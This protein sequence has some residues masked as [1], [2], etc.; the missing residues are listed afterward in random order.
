[1]SAIS[2]FFG[3]YGARRLDGYDPLSFLFSPPSGGD[4]HEATDLD[5]EIPAESWTALDCEVPANWR[6]DEWEARPRRFIDG[7]DVGDTAAWLLAPSGEPVPVRLSQIGA[8]IIE[9]EDGEMSRIWEEVEPVVSFVADAFP[10]DDVERFARDLNASGMRLLTARAPGEGGS[11]VADFEPMRKAAQ[12]RATDEMIVLEKAAIAYTFSQSPD[13]PVVV[14][15]R[16]EPRTGSF[17]RAESPVI[18]VIKTHNKNYLHAGGLGLLYQLNQAQRSPAFRLMGERLPVVSW[19]LRFA[20][21]NGSLPNTGYVRVE[22]AWDWFANQFGYDLEGE[23]QRLS[24]SGKY[25][26]NCLSRLLFDYRCSDASY[27]RAAISLEPIV[28]AEKRLG[29]LLLSSQALLGRFYHLGG[30]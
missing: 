26:I 11:L 19:Y 7:K 12:N 4:E 18:G 27:G 9:V 15:G 30:L 3:A 23:K 6:A 28:C 25:H 14:D 2:D 1:M 29:A 5:F 10:W 16:L 20:G 8:T 21:G 24:S 22:I 17:K 13:V